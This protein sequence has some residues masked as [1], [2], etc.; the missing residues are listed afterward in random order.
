[1]Y[2]QLIAEIFRNIAKILEIK[3]ENVFRIRAYERAAQNIESLSED[4]AELVKEDRL[5]D[6]PG[7]GKDLEKKIKE[8]IKTNRLKFY[9]HLKKTIPPGLLDL[10]NIP[11]IGPKTAKVLY[12]KL[13]IRNIPDLEKAIKLAHI[14]DIVILYDQPYNRN[15]EG[16]EIPANII[17]VK[18][19]DEVYRVIRNLS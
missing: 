15:P 5:T 7:I 12:E 11:S 8:I 18:S 19:W 16:R 1:M 4:V 17:R 2:N 3:G 9:N 10:L 6:I 13:R 14:C